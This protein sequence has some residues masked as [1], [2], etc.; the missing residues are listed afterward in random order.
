MRIKVRGEGGVMLDAF[1]S[2]LKAPSNRD[3]ITWIGGGFVVVIG[4][5][6]AVVKYFAK[7]GGER[8]TRRSAAGHSDRRQSMRTG[9][10]QTRGR[11]EG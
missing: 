10:Y 9:N 2:L 4:G 11:G 3:V 5:V 8:R 1:W 7:P 6:W